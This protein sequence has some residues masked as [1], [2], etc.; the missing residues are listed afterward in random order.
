MNFSRND[1]KNDPKQN[2]SHATVTVPSTP[3]AN[4]GK[5][6]AQADQ[7]G[8]DAKPAVQAPGSQ[9][10]AKHD[11]QDGQRDARTDQQATASNGSGDKAGGDSMVSEGGHVTPGQTHNAIR[12]PNSPTSA[13]RL[14]A[15]GPAENETGKSDLSAKS[16]S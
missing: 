5:G 1:S 8:N 12:E 14:S 13:D 2:A 9:D 15:K 11:G 10:T 3:D 16:A 7:K 6:P 4:K